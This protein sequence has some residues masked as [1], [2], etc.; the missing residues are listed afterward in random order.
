[1]LLEKQD[2][3]QYWP[4]DDNDSTDDEL[5]KDAPEARLNPNS[6]YK[7]YTYVSFYCKSRLLQH[8]ISCL[9]WTHQ[10]SSSERPSTSTI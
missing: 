6:Q 4:S 3:L 5:Q 7:T 8:I 1:M 10:H 9:D 2:L